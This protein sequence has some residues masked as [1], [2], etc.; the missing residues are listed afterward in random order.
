[1]TTGQSF[2]LN[3]TAVNCLSIR[4]ITGPSGLITPVPTTSVP[5]GS[6]TLTAPVVGAGLLSEVFTYTIVSDMNP[7]ASNYT[8]AGISSTVSVTVDQD[9]VP[10]DPGNFTNLDPVTPGSPLTPRFFRS[11]V[12]TITGISTQ[13]TAVV[14][15]PTSN[16]SDGI[17]TVNTPGL[18]GEQPSTS[19]QSSKTIKP[20]DSIQLQ[21]A[22]APADG[23]TGYLTTTTVTVDFKDPLNVVRLTKSF[24]VKTSACQRQTKQVTFGDAANSVTLEYDVGAIYTN[25]ATGSQVSADLLKGSV[26]SIGS[27]TGYYAVS[28]NTGL[29]INGTQL[30]WQTLVNQTISGFTTTAQRPPTDTEILSIFNS[31]NP[32]TLVSISGLIPPTLRSTI[33]TF[34]SGVA[35]RDTTTA[36][37]DTPCQ[38]NIIA[39][40]VVYV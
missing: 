29:F 11:T 31:I 9:F 21:L 6:I 18:T 34:A 32:N 33:V 14:R 27:A 25:R 12:L 22:A 2:T 7:A 8:A 16:G 37:L 15:T 4:S 30:T 17:L 39:P 20:N 40:G 28:G 5:T 13:L 35:N 24:S 23:P 19:V 36:I 38:A 26:S 3:W 10:N 1:V